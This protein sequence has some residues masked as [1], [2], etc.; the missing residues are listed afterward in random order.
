MKIDM[1]IKK[2]ED[3]KVSGT[4]KMIRLVKGRKYLLAELAGIHFNY[5]K[6][7]K[8]NPHSSENCC[9]DFCCQKLFYLI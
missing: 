7:E 9:G 8:K 5:K 4:G 3:Y 1:H 2:S 6:V